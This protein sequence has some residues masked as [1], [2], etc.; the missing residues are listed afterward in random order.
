MWKDSFSFIGDFMETEKKYSI[1]DFEKLSLTST[2]GKAKLKFGIYR[3]NPRVT[4]YTNEPN[5]ANNNYG[6]ITAALDPVA[7]SSMMEILKELTEKSG[8][9]NVKYK[10]DSLTLTPGEPGQKR[11]T[12]LVASVLIGKDEEGVIWITVVAD[13]R[14]KFKFEFGDFK[15]HKFYRP[16][17]SQMSKTELSG[18]AAKATA[19]FLNNIFATYVTTNYEHTPPS[20]FKKGSGG[21]NKRPTTTYDGDDIPY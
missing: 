20:T 19:N 17:G 16:D 6:M 9:N 11:E 1:F 5:D 15:F 18:I 13:G 3:N 21:Y 8:A 12:K 4:V 14:P 7:F 10:I 2:Q